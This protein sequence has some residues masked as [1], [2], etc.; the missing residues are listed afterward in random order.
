MAY[1]Y[2]WKPHYFSGAC[3]L[4][5]VALSLLSLLSGCNGETNLEIPA[6]RFS[7]TNNV[8]PLSQEVILQCNATRTS[9][10]GADALQQIKETL[11]Q[12]T[13]AKR[14]D[15]ADILAETIEREHSAISAKLGRVPR[16]NN[17]VDFDVLI[18]G[19]GVHGATASASLIQ[20][21][22]KLKVLVIDNDTHVA[23]HFRNY[24]YLINSPSKPLE[25]NYFPYAPL[26]IGEY[27]NL[28]AVTK[29]FPLA[30]QVWNQAVFSHLVA[31][32]TLLL[33]TEISRIEQIE[34]SYLVKLDNLTNKTSQTVLVNKIIIATGVGEESWPLVSD[35]DWFA[36]QRTQAQKALLSIP[37]KLPTLI[38]YDELIEINEQMVGAGQSLFSLLRGKKI[39]VLGAGDSGKIIVEFLT[40]FGP[41][42]A[43]LV[44]GSN[45]YEQVSSIAWLN[46]KYATSADFKAGADTKPRYKN[47]AFDTI[48]NKFDALGNPL[49]ISMIPNKANTVSPT[50]NG[51]N[52][53]LEAS[54]QTLDVDIVVVAIG[55]RPHVEDFLTA[56]AHKIFSN[57]VSLKWVTQNVPARDHLS[58]TTE[59]VG[60]QACE[61]TCHPIFIAG[62]AAGFKKADISPTRLNDC[63]TKNDAS[64][65]VL[66]PL[67]Q[68]LA[69][70]IADDSI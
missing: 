10:D 9:I 62:T 26:Q 49:S 39:A 30:H 65:E 54:N 15:C 5:F 34:A 51:A 37:N 17:E 1:S 25:I 59:N 43:Y 28:I 45:K 46:Q 48:F 16:V 67:T 7:V 12:S 50:A 27:A 66:L 69:R 53:S 70:A 68:A 13:P 20:K 21:N 32:Q 31:N 6:T 19:G 38:T 44:G 52:I 2:Y 23:K 33:N 24:G 57:D 47:N 42:K 8:V 64:I 3:M 41:D 56:R 40:G 55:Y 63:K 14:E 18:V 4:F 22:P 58:Q 29:P 60:K 11:N 35:S 61:K 36:S